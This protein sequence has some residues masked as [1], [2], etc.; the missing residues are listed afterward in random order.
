MSAYKRIRA[1]EVDLGRA[2]HANGGRNADGDLPR[3]TDQPVEFI[4]GEVGGYR[5]LR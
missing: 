3:L 2:R 5:T 1:N 4:E